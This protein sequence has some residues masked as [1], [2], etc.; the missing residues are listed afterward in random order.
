V[1]QQSSGGFASIASA[2]VFIISA[3]G[4][5]IPAGGRTLTFKNLAF[6]EL[7]G[8]NSEIAVEQYISVSA[9]YVNHTKQMGMVKPPQVTL[10]RGVDSDLALWYWHNM[11][12]QGLPHARTNVTLEMY[13]GGTPAVGDQAQPMFTYTLVAA[14]CAKIN[15]SGAKAGEGLVTEDVTIV[16]DVIVAGDG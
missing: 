7:S 3:P 16:C 5:Q 2:P 9:G 8:I 10:K 11:A 14:W 6:Q 15:I 4:L 13:G 1:A 12:L